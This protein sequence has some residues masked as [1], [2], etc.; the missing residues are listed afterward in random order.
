ME[1]VFA[2]ADGVFRM[3]ELTGRLDFAIMV[4]GIG[5]G[6]FGGGFLHDRFGPRPVALT[7]ALM[8][9]LGYL[10]AGLGTAHFGLLWLYLTYGIVGGI[11]GGM[12]YLVPGAVVTKWFPR[13]RGLANGVTLFGFGAGS[14][15]YNAIVAAIPQFA[16]AADVATPVIMARHDAARAGTS[17]ILSPHAHAADIHAVMA[18]LFWSGVVMIAIGGLSA[19]GIEAPRT[20]A[21]AIQPDGERDYSPRKMLRTRAF[22]AIWAIVFIDCFAGLALLANAV[23]IYS[24]LTGVG[25]LKATVIYGWLSIFNGIGRL[26]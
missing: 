17:L 11:G 3:D 16:R 24:E 5:I 1:L 10:L 25:A 8:W 18:I 13:H 7:G 23:P 26:L 21:T 15:V 6:A 2:A 9:G 4:F 22:Y 19:L 12:A 14:L 20:V